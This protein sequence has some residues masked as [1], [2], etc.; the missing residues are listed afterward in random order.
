MLNYCYVQGSM[1]GFDNIYLTR[2][3]MVSASTNFFH[4]CWN[5]L[6]FFECQHLLSV[7][8]CAIALLSNLN[9]K[10]NIWYQLHGKYSANVN[11]NYFYSDYMTTTAF[12]YY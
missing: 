7:V 9:M 11:Y 10:I 3:V 6:A 8:S 1:L 5:K 2:E 4:S 12:F